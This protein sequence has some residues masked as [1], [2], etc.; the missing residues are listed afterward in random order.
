MLHGSDGSLVPAISSSRRWHVGP[1]MELRA[2]HSD[3]LPLTVSV[4]VSPA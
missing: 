4:Q 3:G 1:V 2:L